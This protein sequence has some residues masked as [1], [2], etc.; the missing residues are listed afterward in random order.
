LNRAWLHVDEFPNVTIQI[1]K[2]VAIHKT[3]VLRFIVVAPPAATALRTI[4][5]TFTRLSRDKPT[6]TSVYFLASQISLGVKV[7][8]FSLLAAYENIVSHDHACSRLVG[9]LLIKTEAE[10]GEKLD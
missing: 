10:L 8:N 3:M 7:L 6:S 1:L 9:K 4:S 5:S 2:S